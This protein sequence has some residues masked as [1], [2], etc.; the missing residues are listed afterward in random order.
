MQ[1]TSPC[2]PLCLDYFSGGVP[3][4]ITIEGTLD[5]LSR[6]INREAHG[7]NRVNELCLIG[8]VS[9]AEAFFKDQFA[10][11]LNIEPSLAQGLAKAGQDVLLDP[12][13]LLLHQSDWHCKLGFLIS[14]KHDFGTWKKINALYSA[15][16]G[17]S[18]FSKEEGRFFEAL[19]RDRNLL[20][21][22]GGVLTTAYIAQKKAEKDEEPLDG[23][24][25][26]SLVVTPEYLDER[27]RFIR[28]LARKT[29][30]QVCKRLTEIALT[31]PNAYS[32]ERKKAVD[33]IEWWSGD[34]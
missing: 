19:L 12:V 16:L 33:A 31:A 5:D 2:E 27:I 4:G 6:A 18:P 21:H 1:P 32:E 17:I 24:F 22:H 20:V 8:L 34:E 28:E 25:W 13:A 14:E 30:K 10:A 26:N 7:L 9:Y 29:T 11:V 3:P 23:P 15:M